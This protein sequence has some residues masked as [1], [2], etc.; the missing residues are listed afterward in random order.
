MMKKWIALILSF[1]LVITLAACGAGTG[2]TPADS[3]S[4]NSETEN[5]ST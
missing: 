1:V 3:T 2:E 5:P 4:V